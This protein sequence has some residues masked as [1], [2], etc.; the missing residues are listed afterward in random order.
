MLE[1]L[2]PEQIELI[3][4]ILSLASTLF[5]LVVSVILRCRNRKLQFSFYTTD[6]WDST[7]LVIRNV[8]SRTIFIDELYIHKT[9]WIEFDIKSRFIKGVQGPLPIE[10]GKT[11][12]TSFS[13][14]ELRG[15]LKTSIERGNVNDSWPKY[16]E[17]RLGFK[18]V[19]STS[20]GM[21]STRWFK[22]GYWQGEGKCRQY[23]FFTYRKTYYELRSYFNS[24]DWGMVSLLPIMLL[25][26]GFMGY[27]MGESMFWPLMITGYI[28]LLIIST[29]YVTDG[30][31]NRNEVKK[32]AVGITVAFSLLI[33]TVTENLMST[34]VLS[35]IVLAYHYLTIGKYSGWNM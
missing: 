10:P 16:S 31:P 21:G 18:I 24:I 15:I 2:N 8:G 11:L 14:E 5:T 25:F 28:L 27:Y 20:E 12:R 17:C 35:L 33:W 1:V 6:D 34:V 4:A 7:I 13:E 23:D 32:T 3:A 30:L 19:A 22:I 29:M 9:H 26:F